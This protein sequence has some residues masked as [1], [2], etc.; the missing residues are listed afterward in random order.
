MEED[1][2]IRNL[3]YT[4]EFKEYYFLL[5]ERTKDK[6][7]YCFDILETIYVLN[8]KFVKKLSETNDNLYE[9]RVSVD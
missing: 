7:T 6:Y 9:L 8:S 3:F 2:K 1:M 4:D 5:D